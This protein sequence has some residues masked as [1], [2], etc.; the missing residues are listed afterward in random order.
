MLLAV[1]RVCRGRSLVQTRVLVREDKADVDVWELLFDQQVFLAAFNRPEALCFDKE[2]APWFRE[3]K[4]RRILR[5]SCWD[6]I[7]DLVSFEL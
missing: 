3:L 6:Y 4:V 7:G 1:S 2:K 5:L